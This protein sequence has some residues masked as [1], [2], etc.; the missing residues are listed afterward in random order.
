MPGGTTQGSS[1]PMQSS[2]NQNRSNSVSKVLPPSRAVSYQPQQKRAVSTTRASTVSTTQ[3]TSWGGNGSSPVHPYSDYH[4]MNDDDPQQQSRGVRPRPPPHTASNF[5]TSIQYQRGQSNNP[6]D[7]DNDVEDPHH[8]TEAI[9]NLRERRNTGNFTASNTQT[10]QQR[11]ESDEPKKRPNY[12]QHQQQRPGASSPPPRHRSASAPRPNADLPITTTPGKR[13]PQHRSTVQNV[14]L[15]PRSSP[16]EVRATANIQRAE[17]KIDGLLQE[18]EDLRFLEEIDLQDATPPMARSKSVP[19]KRDESAYPLKTPR[20]DTIPAIVRAISPPA[21]MPHGGK[22]VR[23]LPPPTAQ[24]SEPSMVQILSPRRISKMDRMA[25]ELETQTLCRKVDV[26]AKEKYTLEKAVAMYEMTLQD[27]EHE[28]GVVQQL[29]MDLRTVRQQLQQAKQDVSAVREQVVTEYE[30][31]L[32]ENVSKLQRTQAAVDKYQQDRLVLQQEL[33]NIRQEYKECKSR[34]KDDE[35][36]NRM[37][38]KE[39]ESELELQLQE[40]ADLADELKEQYEGEK[41]VVRQLSIKLKDEI[42]ARDANI[43]QLQE[44]NQH[45]MS[46]SKDQLRTFQQEWRSKLTVKDR[47]MEQLRENLRQSEL[48]LEASK[49]AKDE[50]YEVHVTSLQEQLSLLKDKF[51]QSELEKDEAL[52]TLEGQNDKV[53]QY[54]S[55]CTEQSSLIKDMTERLDAVHTEYRDKFVELKEAY[56]TKEKR[57]LQDMVQTHTTEVD[58]YERRLKALQEQLSH[59][60]DRHHAEIEHKTQELLSKLDAHTTEKRELVQDHGQIL[61]VLEEKIVKLK[62]EY[63]RVDRERLLLRQEIDGMP[64]KDDALKERQGRERRDTIRDNEL[65]RL[66]EKAERLMRDTAEKSDQIQELSSKLIEEEKTHSQKVNQLKNLH[67]NALFQREQELSE[68]MKQMRSAEVK[69]RCDLDRRDTETV[70]MKNMMELRISELRNELDETRRGIELTRRRSEE[71]ESQLRGEISVLDGKL[72]A[73]ETI[74]KQKND[75]IDD[76]KERLETS[77]NQEIAATEAHRDEVQRLRKEMSDL[78]ND[79]DKERSSLKAKLLSWE[80]SVREKSSL[81]SKLEG[82]LSVANTKEESTEQRMKDIETAC[83]E[84]KAELIAERTRHVSAEEQT[85][86]DLAV[87]QGKYRASE[88]S[89]KEKRETI[90]ELEDQLRRIADESS[91]TNKELQKEVD[92]LRTEVKKMNDQLDQDRAEL[93]TKNEIL[94]Q[95]QKKLRLHADEILDL[96]QSVAASTQLDEN[97]SRDVSNLKAALDQANSDLD[98]ERADKRNS[99]ES[100]Q[101]QLAS[102]ETKLQEVDAAL[103]LK[104]KEIADLEEKLRLSATESSISVREYQK[105]M[106]QDRQLAIARLEE[107]TSK[108]HSKTVQ[109]EE[110]QGKVAELVI[111]TNR[112]EELEKHLG[113]AAQTERGLQDELDTAQ[114]EYFTLSKALETERTMRLE[115]D[116]HTVAKISE[117]EAKLQECTFDLE[118]KQAL[119]TELQIN[120]KRDSEESAASTT[121][122]KS[123]INSLR[124]DIKMSSELLHRERS[125]MDAKVEE[126]EQVKTLNWNL[127]QK[128]S[129]VEKMES[130]IAELRAALETTETEKATRSVESTAEGSSV[131][132]GMQSQL[133]FERRAK[134]D[135]MTKLIDTQAELEIKEHQLSRLP[136]L[137]YQLKQLVDER[138]ELKAQFGRVEAELD[139][140]YK[141]VDLSSDRNTERVSILEAEL[142]D[143]KN[144][145]AELKSYLNNVELELAMQIEHTNRLKADIKHDSGSAD[146]YSPDLQAKVDL[147][148]RT[149]ASLE[150]KIR[151]LEEDREDREKQVRDSSERYSNQILDLQI[152][153]EELSRKKTTLKNRLSRLEVDLEQKDEQMSVTSSQFSGDVSNLQSMLTERLAENEALKAKL[154]SM[155]SKLLDAETTKDIQVKLDA[156]SKEKRSLLSKIGDIEA[157]LQRKE[158]QIRDVVDRYTRDIAE[159]EYKLEDELRSKALLQRDVD[160]FK[161]GESSLSDAESRSSRENVEIALLAQQRANAELQRQL[162]QLKMDSRT[163]S[164]DASEVKFSELRKA[165]ATL[166]EELKAVTT[167]AATT[168]KR[169]E[170]QLNAVLN[171]KDAFSDRMEF[172]EKLLSLEKSK[173]ELE[174]RLKKV[175]AERAEVTTWMEEVINEVQ[176]R[177]DEIE[178]LVTVVR[179][180]DEEL[181]H[182][183]SIATKALATLQEMK[184]QFK[185]KDDDRLTKFSQKV[186]ELNTN[187]DFLTKK[188]ESLERKITRMEM[189]VQQR[190]LE[191]GE[192]RN[193]LQCKEKTKPSAMRNL[194]DKVENDGFQSIN[195]DFQTFDTCSP[196]TRASSSLVMNDTMSMESAEPPVASGWLHDFDSHSTDDSEDESNISF[197]GIHT[198]PSESQSRR[199]IERNALRKYVRKRYMKS[200]A[201]V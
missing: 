197:T 12:P 93:F 188:N 37:N 34:W 103:Q 134:D 8:M 97:R 141:Q 84:A 7:D 63:D 77:T 142:R 183:K 184:S 162:E 170:D 152:K 22:A 23:P 174:E 90:E 27:H 135:L 56:E 179:K 96:Q 65:N 18:L 36:R 169:L 100:Q 53:L 73:A 31:R 185:K 29:E 15:S 111:K 42:T 167:A 124:Y 187:L 91:T 189:E 66:K 98:S 125:A 161:R 32:Q 132:V 1:R 79:I 74:M 110:L 67:T 78:S 89:L 4:P 151:E 82:M 180:R 39:R 129:R 116:N 47:A 99:L 26:L 192:L 16:E 137:Q 156:E 138:E 109:I 159:L 6:Y 83:R 158:K 68:Q 21:K 59:Q 117:L 201:S 71:S 50:A 9:W 28:N 64:S 160:K 165:N 88:A 101:E 51:N 122:L 13:D 172:E 163:M 41:E 143:N 48:A 121:L 40:V 120:A 136:T 57:R 11:R 87:L 198:A 81:V 35:A 153:V 186:D 33:E 123:E 178:G 113:E 166:Q 126:Y 30:G 45:Q 94:K 10:K 44:E 69:L 2:S 130:V 154:D 177:E 102:T 17:A 14:L 114:D 70:E 5:P 164:S 144:V 173:N 104:L 105:T 25:L 190:E 49:S 195:P 140:K 52:K 149:K 147:L 128:A 80:E 54:Q 191:C 85:R 72:R 108:V 58:E 55:Q 24:P 168:K 20:G 3:R 145:Q 62:Q 46:E 118:K 150:A 193:K 139:G 171:N 148:T 112:I 146:A 115:N 95:Q 157:E 196:T 60:N 194:D 133:A 107:E 199:S 106:E 92:Q 75:S 200:K 131:L 61:S 119:I 127:R 86:V 43:A 175:I 76:L 19:P 176:G 155:E 181:E 182:A 38:Q